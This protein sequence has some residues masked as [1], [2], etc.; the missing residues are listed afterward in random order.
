MMQQ[1][2]PDFL[3]YQS[4]RV[5]YA[6]YRAEIAELLRLAANSRRRHHVALH[7]DFIAEIRGRQHTAAFWQPIP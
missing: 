5:F 3:V 2:A 7:R 6:P 4:P 1:R